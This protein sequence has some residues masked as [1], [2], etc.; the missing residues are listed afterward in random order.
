MSVHSRTVPLALALALTLAGCSF[1]VNDKVAVPPPL[2]A[3]EGL[4][5]VMPDTVI[6]A[7]QEKMTC[8]VPDYTP[9]QDYQV[10]SFEPLQGAYGHHLVAMVSGTPRPPGTVFDCTEV[11]QRA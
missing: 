2:G 5:F 4:Q 11:E 10:V 1:P 3:S 6:P 7:G 9:D 8:W